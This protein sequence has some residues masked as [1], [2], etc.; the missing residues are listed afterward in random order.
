MI[1]FDN[2]FT[3]NPD[4]KILGFA[5][6]VFGLSSSPFVLN[7]TVKIHLEKFMNDVQKRKVIIKLLRDLYVDDAM[8]SIND[9]KE[10]I[11]FYETSK[12]CLLSGKFDLR[13]C[14]T[15]NENLQ[16][17]INSKEHSINLTSIIDKT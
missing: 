14:V 13:K 4:I 8:P 6:L 15:N 10:G 9:T 12:S 2:F 1:W 7:V 11:K 16:T 3:E 17:F 5:R